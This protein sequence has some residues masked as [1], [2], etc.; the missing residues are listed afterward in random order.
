MKDNSR[1]LRH[2][3]T[4]TPGGAAQHDNWSANFFAV[5]HGNLERSSAAESRQRLGKPKPRRGSGSKNDGDDAKAL[6]RGA[7]LFS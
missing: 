2:G 7:V 6:G 3:G 1:A 4:N 5:L